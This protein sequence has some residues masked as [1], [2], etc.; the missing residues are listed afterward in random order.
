MPKGALT[1]KSCERKKQSEPQFGTAKTQLHARDQRQVGRGHK[2]RRNPAVSF[3]HWELKIIALPHLHP[4]IS[5]ISQRVTLS[6]TATQPSTDANEWYDCV[7]LLLSRNN[8]PEVPEKEQKS[9]QE[10]TY[11]T[12]SYPKNFSDVY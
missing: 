5:G 9:G 2:E 8:C 10:D 6:A 4:K 11:E 7:L 3:R 12:L 1:R